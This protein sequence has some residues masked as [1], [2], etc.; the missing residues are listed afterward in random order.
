MIAFRINGEELE[1]D[2]GVNVQVEY[3]NGLFEYDRI[4]AM[5][6]MPLTLQWS[7]KNMR[8]LLFPGNLSVKRYRRE[9]FACE[10]YLDNLWRVGKLFILGTT[11]KGISVNFQSDAGALGDGFK[12]DSLR[13]L[14]LGTE[15]FVDAVRDV[16]PVSN[17]ALFPVKN[18]GLYDENN[19]E[20]SGYVNY[21][22][23]SF[24]V[25]DSV[26][27][28]HTRTPFP[29]LVYILR[30]LFANYG[31][32][33]TGSW[34]EE[35]EIRRLVIFNTKTLDFA[36]SY[37]NVFRTEFA[38]NQ[39]VPDMKVSEFVKAIRATFGLGFVFNSLAKTIEVVKLRDIVRDLSYVDWRARHVQVTKWK[40]NESNG[41]VLTFSPDDNNELN[42]LLP[43]DLVKFKVGGGFTEIPF[44]LGTV[45]VQEDQDMIHGNRHW[46]LPTVDQQGGSEMFATD[47]EF[48]LTLLS[49]R[50]MQPDSNGVL[51]PFATS[52][53]RNYAGDEIGTQ[54]LALAGPKGLHELYHRHWLQF[55]SD[56]DAID[57]EIDLSLTDL[58][59]LKP[60]R[61][62]L[63]QTE[64]STFKA[65]WTKVTVVVSQKDGVK[66]AKA[67]L[68]K[69]S[70]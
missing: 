13:V 1:M 52:G 4:P 40:P 37:V 58:R 53:T 6:T 56:A 10:M 39:H 35:E 59:T 7:K 12:N 63:V 8:L 50:G 19:E 65:L 45:G 27:S 64:Q 11:P 25:N 41:F 55:L 46:L 30:K 28:K 31:Y 61:K 34:L 60:E 70:N 67:P 15:P 51:Y 16:Y 49:Y 32:K 66:I 33:L 3:Y 5:F 9:P 17:Y 36:D 24:Q 68:L 48:S 26:F 23:N 44:N 29:F 69:I 20:Y 22:N 14:D 2:P 57:T 38:Y 42:K 54:E 18:P 47:G 62:V 43:D 21:Y